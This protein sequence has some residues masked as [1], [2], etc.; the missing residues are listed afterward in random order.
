MNKILGIS[1]T[2]W[3]LV[4]IAVFNGLTAIVPQVQGTAAIAIN[5]ILLILTGVMHTIHVNSA[6]VAG[7]T[8]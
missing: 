4:L 6:A 5:V 8:N 3:S 1:L 2:V 7:N